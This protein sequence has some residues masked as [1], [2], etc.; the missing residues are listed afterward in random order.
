MFPRSATWPPRHRAIGRL[1]YVLLL[2]IPLV[3]RRTFDFRI[4][5]LFIV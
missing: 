2:S 4:K 3:L 5:R 1:L